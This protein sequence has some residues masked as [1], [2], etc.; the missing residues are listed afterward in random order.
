MKNCRRRIA[1]ASLLA[2]AAALVTAFAGGL[3]LIGCQKVDGTMPGDVPPKTYLSIVGENLSTTDYRKVLHWWGTDPDGTIRGYLIRWDGGWVIPDSMTRVYEGVTYKFTTAT[4]DT[5]IVPLGDTLAVRHFTVRAVDDHGLVDPTGVTQDFS[6]RSHAPS[7]S[8]RARPARPA[9]SL[10]AVAFG[11]SVHD[12]DGR[13]T[14]HSFHIWFENDANGGRMVS[15][16]TFAL[17]AE[18]FLGDGGMPHY[19]P[20]TLHVVAF[21]EAGVHSDTLSHS[22]NVRAPRGK[23]LWIFQVTGPRTVDYDIP[24]FYDVL[25]SVFPPDSIEVIHL[26]RISDPDFPDPVMIEPLFSLFRAVIWTAG[27]SV[28]ANDVKMARNLRIAEPGMRT[29]VENGGRVML[30]GTALIGTGGGL[31]TTFATQVLGADSLYMRRITNTDNL[32]SDMSLTRGTAVL[33]THDGVVDTLNVMISLLNGEFFRPPI[34]PGAGVYSVAP[35]TLTE[36]TRPQTQP[37]YLGLVASPGRGRIGFVTNAYARFFDYL[38]H[39]DRIGEATRF[40]REV[41]VTP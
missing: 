24:F 6:L 14:V 3:G 15:D 30:M 17:R 18:D 11:I 33:A 10:P 21:D 41:L 16:T 32:T 29:Y 5:F 28:D 19:G 9:E 36:S 25:Y 34:P 26:E 7:I 4:Q 8:W 37:A 38:N 40:F 2:C 20:R 35:G 39:R 13:E 31:S 1:A 22:W 23:Y 27:P 12:F